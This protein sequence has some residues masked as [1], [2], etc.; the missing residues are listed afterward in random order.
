[1]NLKYRKLATAINIAKSG[2]R[3]E[4]LLLHPDE[5][6]KVWSLRRYM[7]DIPPAEAMELVVKR[8]KETKNNVEFLMALK[9]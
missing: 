9:K 7:N 6:E 4:E 2:T 1:M 5:L 3:R 8:I